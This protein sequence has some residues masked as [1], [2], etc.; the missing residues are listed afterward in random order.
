[1]LLCFLPPAICDIQCKRCIQSTELAVSEMRGFKYSKV[2][3]RLYIPSDSDSRT[4][5][6]WTNNEFSPEY[7]KVKARIR[8][9]RIVGTKIKLFKSSWT[10]K[11]NHRLIQYPKPGKSAIP[12]CKNQLFPASSKSRTPSPTRNRF[13]STPT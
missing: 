2:R 7:N 6:Q 1:M 4:T 3:S 13:L 9:T 10:K 8:I 12:I 11:R 5:K